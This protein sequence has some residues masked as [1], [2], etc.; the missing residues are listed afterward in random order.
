LFNGGSSWEVIVTQDDLGGHAIY[1]HLVTAEILT[2]DPETSDGRFAHFKDVTSV[3]VL[4]RRL[5]EVGLTLEAMRPVEAAWRRS[6]H[7]TFPPDHEIHFQAVELEKSA[8]SR[9]ER[10]DM[11]QCL[12]SGTNV[13]LMTFADVRWPTGWKP[14]R[15]GRRAI[16]ADERTA[17]TAHD[18]A[19]LSRLYSLLG[20][21]CESVRAFQEASDFYY[22]EMEARRLATPLPWRI[23]SI[24]A[25][26]KYLS[27]DGENYAIALTWLI[28]MVLAIFPLLYYLISPYQSVPLAILHSLRVSTFLPAIKEAAPVRAQF[29]EGIE[30]IVVAL[31]V[32]LTTLAIKR[33]FGRR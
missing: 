8:D 33:R 11:R 13:D 16:V 15:L 19:A 25:A 20:K 21:N 31:Q 14:L 1:N 5:G 29:A 22:G 17:K 10:V 3:E 27:G 7:A 23:L 6:A 9:M 26:Y 32:A 4:R 12:L 2:P 28:A 24:P 18:F 30:R